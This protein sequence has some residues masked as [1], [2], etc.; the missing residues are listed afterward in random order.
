MT[1]IDDGVWNYGVDEFIVDV[2]NSWDISAGDLRVGSTPL[3]TGVY[4]ALDIPPGTTQGSYT[5]TITYTI[6]HT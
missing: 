6:Y 1:G 5:A 4:W 2:D 3:V